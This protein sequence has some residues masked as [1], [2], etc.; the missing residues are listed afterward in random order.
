MSKDNIWQVAADHD[1]RADHDAD[2][3]GRA[4]RAG[5][6]ESPPVAQFGNPRNFY[7]NESQISA[8][9]VPEKLQELFLNKKSVPLI[10][11]RFS[12]P[13]QTQKTFLSYFLSLFSPYFSIPLK[14]GT[15]RSDGT[16]LRCA[17]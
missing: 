1:G 2:H 16:A 6:M 15:N 4:H 3:D 17:Q 12:Y 7:S 9:V 13:N 5:G 8:R 10:G 14:K 11:C